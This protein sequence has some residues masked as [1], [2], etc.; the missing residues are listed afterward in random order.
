MKIAILTSGR[1]PV[2]AVLGGAVENLTDY[3]LEYNNVYHLHHITVYS[4]K[5]D[6]IVSPDTEYNH[7][8]YVDIKSTMAKIARIIHAKFNKEAYY[9]SEIEYFLHRSLQHLK[10]QD[11]DCVILE[12]RPGYAM[13]VRRVTN[14]KIILHLHNDLLN[15]NTYKANEIISCLS[16]VI[17][18]SNFIKGR[19]ETIGAGIPVE[20]VHNGIDL[21]RFQGDSR[22]TVI[23]R[24]ALGL[25][26]DDFVV[27]YSGRLTK[28][29]GIKELL[30]TFLLLK[31]YEKI[32]LLI[33]GG[34]FYGNGNS[35]QSPFMTELRQ[36]A[37][38]MQKKVIFTGY[39]DYDNVPDYLRLGNVAVVPSMW[40]EPFALTCVEAMAVGLPLIATRVGGIPEV[41]KDLA[42]LVD[43]DNVIPELCKTLCDLFFDK[44]HHV[45]SPCQRKMLSEKYNK[46]RYSLEFYNQI[47]W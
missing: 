9:D 18:V 12:N 37:E 15:K 21:E 36:I 38:K 13:A 45:L 43:K 6:K 23:T 24:S 5:S 39:V 47:T 20:T 14:A 28:E 25:Q 22:D 16:K 10:K 46:I 31:D 32:K 7:Y 33:I 30:E 17:T 42:I 35:S 4:I 44:S 3:Y 1:L 11:Y 19:V 2:P 27:V 40:E 26:A 41:C 8:Y 34:S 29:K